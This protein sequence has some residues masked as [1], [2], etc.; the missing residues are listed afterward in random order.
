MLR[1]HLHDD[2]AVPVFELVPEDDALLGAEPRVEGGQP[3][4]DHDLV[5]E[6]GARVLAR[7]AV[8][9]DVAV[10]AA[11]VARAPDVQRHLRVEPPHENLRPT[12]PLARALQLRREA[13][14]VSLAMEAAMMGTMY[15][16]WARCAQHGG[17]AS[18]GGLVCVSLRSSGL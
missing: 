5:A 4:Q 8:A 3:P 10:L 13:R 17:I 9:V 11:A 7:V 1:T 12:L 18:G 15:F 14:M 6:G 2:V 16:L